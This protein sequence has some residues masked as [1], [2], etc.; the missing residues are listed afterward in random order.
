M[1]K[2]I[3]RVTWYIRIIPFL[4]GRLCQIYREFL[5]WFRIYVGCH[6]DHHGKKADKANL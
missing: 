4:P 1:T 2:D 5:I 3:Q 6:L